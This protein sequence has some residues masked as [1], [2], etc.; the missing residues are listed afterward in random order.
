MGSMVRNRVVYWRSWLHRGIIA[1][2]FTIYLI[3]IQCQTSFKKEEEHILSVMIKTIF[4]AISLKVKGAGKIHK[5]QVSGAY[6]ITWDGER[7]IIN[8]R[9][10]LSSDYHGWLS[11][12]A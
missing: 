11:R 1:P 8:F 4:D 7:E 3:L 5:R 2:K 10:G 9:R 12:V 6:C